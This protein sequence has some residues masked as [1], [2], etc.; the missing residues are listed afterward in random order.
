MIPG[1][2]PAGALVTAQ[3]GPASMVFNGTDESLQRT[4]AT[5]SPSTT[6]A[7]IS[8]WL[9]VAATSGIMGFFQ[10]SPFSGVSPSLF[11]DFDVTPGFVFLSDWNEDWGEDTT[12]VAALNTWEHWVFRYDSTQATADNR[13]RFYKNNAL[14]T[15]VNDASPPALNADHGIFV[16]GQPMR[17]GRASSSVIPGVT[18]FH[19]SL[20][21]IDVLEGVSQ[22][23]TAFAFDNGGTWTRKPYAGSYG[24]YGFS[25]DGS[26]L[27]NDVSGNGQH[28]TP[29]GM[30]A[31]NLNTSDLPP[32][33]N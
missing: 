9:K 15:D 33:T 16:D 22:D 3:G 7:T 5:T 6:I 14:I 31:S 23:A 21:F 30:D 29:T 20:A 26:D 4:L 24:T 8:M 10:T 27:F 11:I 18:R 28:F 25:L 12:I 32:Y 1:M 17:I 19:G 13:I 2:F